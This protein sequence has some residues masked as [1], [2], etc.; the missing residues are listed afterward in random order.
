MKRNPVRSSPK[1]VPELIRSRPA[2]SATHGSV[3]HRPTTLNV[4]IENA[5][6]KHRFRTS[7]K[8]V[9]ARRPS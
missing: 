4:V 3:T 8:S 6:P 7:V 9:R 5:M 2:V 1:D